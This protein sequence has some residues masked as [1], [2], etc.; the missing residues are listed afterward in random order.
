MELSILIGLFNILV[1]LMLVTSILLMGGGLILWYVRLG[2]FPTYRDDAI[3][4]MEW[5]VAILFV[6]V[7]LLGIAQF[8]QTH[9]AL[10]MM[11]VGAVAAAVATYFV[12]SILLAPEKKEDHS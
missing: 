11:A 4:M 5:S 3:H 6:L 12:A 1:G 2:T 9:L 7:V 8:V 10:A